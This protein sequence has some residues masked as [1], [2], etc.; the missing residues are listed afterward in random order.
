MSGNFARINH[1]TFY[2]GSASYRIM[3]S[4]LVV[5]CYRNKSIPSIHRGRT[6]T[7]FK[8]DLQRLVVTVSFDSVL[9]TITICVYQPSAAMAYPFHNVS[10]RFSANVP[11]GHSPTSPIVKIPCVS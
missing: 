11:F 1:H 10:L 4:R 7:D 3:V 6:S 9:C 8:V 5:G 2:H